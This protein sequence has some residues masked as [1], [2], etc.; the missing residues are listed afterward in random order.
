MTGE[1]RKPLFLLWVKFMPILKNFAHGYRT[2][3]ITDS[4]IQKG[5]NV[6]LINTADGKSIYRS[7]G[8]TLINQISDEKI[9]GGFDYEKGN[10]HHHLIFTKN[11]IESKVYLL[12]NGVFTLLKDSMSASAEHFNAVNYNNGVFITNGIDNPFFYEYGANPEV[13]DIDATSYTGED[14]RGL[15]PKVFDNRIFIGSGSGLYSCGLGDPFDWSSSEVEA[16]RA[17]YINNFKNR[18]SEIVALETYKDSLIIHRTTDTVKLSGTSGSYN[19]DVISNVGCISPFAIA[20]L[21]VYQLYFIK[22]INGTGLYYLS[23]NDLGV[24]KAESEISVYIHEEFENIDNSRLDKVYVLPLTAK[25][26]VWIH[27]PRTDY[28][29]NAYWIIYNL[30]SKCF[31]PPRITQPITA[32]WIFEGEIYTGTS[33]GKIL[34][35]GLG[36]TF[37]GS[38]IEAKARLN[39]IS[40]GTLLKKEAEE[41]FRVKIDNKRNT[42]FF[43]SVIK[44]DDERNIK[45]KQIIDEDSDA[46]IWGQSNWGDNWTVFYPKILKKGKPP[47]CKQYSIEF[48][49]TNGDFGIHI[50]EYPDMVVTE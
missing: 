30:S 29:D 36:N 39:T 47:K 12:E 42:N 2:N 5:Y 16:T 40:F 35:E 27:I 13:Q 8:N 46:M 9:I 6:E 37:D 14:I 20:N 24:I 4:S 18:S 28:P 32:A 43:L 15:S 49:T 7:M 19:M 26:Q 34:I 1:Q 45:S 44:D 17:G 11:D 38:V 41:K 33:D 48:S 3:N 50:V 21:D 23:S 10:T 22:H 25:N 31:F